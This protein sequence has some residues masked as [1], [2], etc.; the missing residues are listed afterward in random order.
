MAVPSRPDHR[1]VR[2]AQPD[3]V[4]GEREAAA[5]GALVR[6]VVGQGEGLQAGD[7]LLRPVRQVPAEDAAPQREAEVAGGPRA[8]HG[9]HDR[10]EVDQVAARRCERDPCNV[11]DVLA[12][13]DH[14]LVDRGDRLELVCHER[15]DD[16]V[17]GD[18]RDLRFTG[19]L[20]RRVML[21]WDA[22]DAVFVPG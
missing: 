7:E 5:E 16:A 9:D 21:G 15:R 17:G 11:I 19:G 6:D 10:L 14:A 22:G 20:D 3:V 4:A 12:D 18:A 1:A 8:G 13:E 2:Q